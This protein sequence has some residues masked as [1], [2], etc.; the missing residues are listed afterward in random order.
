MGVVNTR[1]HKHPHLIGSP[2]IHLGKAKCRG[3]S[4]EID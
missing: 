4:V 3:M 2:A 1:I